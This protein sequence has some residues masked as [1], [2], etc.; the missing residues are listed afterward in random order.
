M[1]EP[2]RHRFK[3]DIGRLRTATNPA[4][5]SVMPTLIVFSGLPGAGSMQSVKIDP[6][7]DP[8]RS[9]RRHTALLRRLHLAE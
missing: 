4:I 1:W 2:A 6:P 9:D 5:I 3:A 7:L 8:I